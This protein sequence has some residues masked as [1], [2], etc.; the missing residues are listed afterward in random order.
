MKLSIITVCLNS[1]KTIS[2]TINSV[3]SQTYKNIEHV[4]VDGGSTDNT[5]NELKNNPN[6]KKKIIIAKKTNIYEAMN[7]GIK[8]CSGDIIHI[9]NSD[10][11]FSSNKVIERVISKIKENYQYGIFCGHVTYFSNSNFNKIKRYYKAEGNLF[12]KLKYGLI[13]PH[14]G[15]FI[16]REIYKKVSFYNENYKIAGD[17]D[18]FLRAIKLMKIKYKLLNFEIVRMRLGGKSTTSF[19]NYLFISKEIIKSLSSNNVQYN[20]F[21]IYLRFLFKIKEIFIKNELKSKLKFE[22]FNIT[23]NQ[24]NYEKKMFKIYRDVKKINFNK[25]IILS[26]MNLAYLGYY[27]KKILYPLKYL[28]HWPD[29]IFLK[30]IINIK[31]IAGRDLLNKIKLDKNIKSIK[32]I[33]NLDTI[34][35][36]YLEKK[37]KRN[38]THYIIP[39]LSLN[40]ISKQRIKIKKSELV[41]ITLPT[42]KQEVLAKSISK[43]NRYYKIICIG[44]SI[45]IA[46]GL[47]KKVP[48]FLENY[49]YIWRLKN[50]FFR[51][52]KRLIESYIFY[53][54]GIKN[55]RYENTIFKII[56]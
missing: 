14:P 30:K 33:G 39:Y 35:L 43:N 11:I 17:F 26:A 42:P 27:Q 53:L 21:I 23:H 54:M 8:E 15:S 45:N 40:E 41:F 50:D 56:E 20:L 49:E 2:D 12:L 36:K 22:L 5:L 1:I 25:N 29:G 31:K 51:R 55:K 4:F 32:V 3:N 19:Y 47:E 37:Y 6:K 16:K 18:F 38:V 46:S 52:L 9:L 34:A 48:K 7:I 13:P 24:K 10:D 28:F 44:G